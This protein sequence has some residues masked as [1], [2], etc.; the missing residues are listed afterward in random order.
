MTTES[1]QKM[2]DYVSTQALVKLI[3]DLRVSARDAKDMKELMSIKSEIKNYEILLNSFV[4]PFNN[5]ADY[6]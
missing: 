5:F 1:Q 3:Q 2:E 4:K 6:I